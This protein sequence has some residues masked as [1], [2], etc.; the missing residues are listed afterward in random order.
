[1]PNEKMPIHVLFYNIFRSHYDMINVLTPK[2]GQSNT[3]CWPFVSIFM[4]WLV[5]VMEDGRYAHEILAILKLL[6]ILFEVTWF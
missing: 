6:A 1:M 4:Y 2:N 3:P 5:L